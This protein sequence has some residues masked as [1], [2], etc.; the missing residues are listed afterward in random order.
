MAYRVTVLE[1]LHVMLQT[2]MLSWF[3]YHQVTPNKSIECNIKGSPHY[4]LTNPFLLTGVKS[5]MTLC[6]KLDK[7]YN[8]EYYTEEGRLGW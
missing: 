1:A 3:P 7:M 4:L 8:R 6:Y 2:R 5:G